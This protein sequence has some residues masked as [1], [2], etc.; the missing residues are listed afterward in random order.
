VFDLLYSWSDGFLLGAEYLTP[1]TKTTNL[2]NQRKKDKRRE[3]DIGG[4]RV[5]KTKKRQKERKS[6]ILKE[7]V[8]RRA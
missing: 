1:T 6:H 7:E 2:E 5:R 4:E 3:R 8:T